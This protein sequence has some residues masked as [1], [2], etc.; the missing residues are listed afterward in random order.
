MSQSA[1]R[2]AGSWTPA[3]IPDLSGLTALVTGANSGLGWHT[4]DELA[5]HGARVLMACRDAAR[6]KQ[7]IDKVRADVPQ[8][9]VEVVTLDLADLG[10][11]RR[12]AEEL[13]DSLARLDL[14][15]NN[16]GVM[17]LPRRTTSDGFELQFGTN[18][19]G[20][21]ALTGL[22]LPVLLRGGVPAHNGVDA[23]APGPPRVVTVSSTLH[24]RGRIT[25]KDDG[26]HDYTPWR[27]L[28]SSVQPVV[29]HEP[30]RRARPV[31]SVQ[32]RRPSRWAA[33]NLQA[34]RDRARLG[35]GGERSTPFAQSAEHGAWPTRAPRAHRP[36]AAA[37]VLGPGA[38][39]A[40]RVPCRAADRLGSTRRPRLTLAALGELAGSTTP[41]SAEAATPT[42]D[43]G[44]PHYVQRPP[45]TEGA[46][47]SRQERQRAA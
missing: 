19:L 40:A 23:A 31:P 26:E 42:P 43:P 17:A 29:V 12:V 34:A 16:A 15:I 1:T 37:V 7:A 38:R 21:F 32:P 47:S 13:V 4:A 5:R 25:A 45:R 3:D 6:A 39:R 28:Q 2:T 11:V 8:A 9:E 44:S 30:Q 14:L 35:G 10:S 36:L 27:V 22:L 41:S 46:G 33:T 18:H 24:R 20:H